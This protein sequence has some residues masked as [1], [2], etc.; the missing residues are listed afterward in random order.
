MN[1]HS[2][3]STVPGITPAAYEAEGG[4]TE[5]GLEDDDEDGA[6]FTPR[7]GD[8]LYVGDDLLLGTFSPTPPEPPPPSSLS[9]NA[10]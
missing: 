5:D 3:T 2:Q 9:K 1:P 10:S 6:G 8:D 7:V 4:A